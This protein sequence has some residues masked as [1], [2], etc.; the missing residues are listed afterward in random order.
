MAKPATT[1]SGWGWFRFPALLIYICI[2]NVWSSPFF[3]LPKQLIEW[4]S[5]SRFSWNGLSTAYFSWPGCSPRDASPSMVT[6]R[7]GRHFLWRRSAYTPHPCVRPAP[8]NQRRDSDRDAPRPCS[9]AGEPAHPCAAVRSV[10][11]DLASRRKDIH[12]HPPGLRPLLLPVARLRDLSPAPFS[13]DALNAE[14]WDL[15]F[16]VVIWLG[17]FGL[18]PLSPLAFTPSYIC[19]R[20]FICLSCASFDA[21]RLDS[22]SRRSIYS[23]SHWQK[24][25]IAWTPPLPSR[26]V[27]TVHDNAFAA[28]PHQT[29]AC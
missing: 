6:L 14:R 22:P 19:L 26:I 24:T 16:D 25:A 5:A 13:R 11:R 15:P 2:V 10:R 21:R 18:F 8:A 27:S 28:N 20:L 23:P 9:A 29:G 1:S 7:T 12:P 17:P 3:R 4:L